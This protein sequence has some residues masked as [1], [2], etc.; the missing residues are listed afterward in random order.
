MA[1]LALAVTVRREVKL[2]RSRIKTR[3]RP[4]YITEQQG[5]WA[6]RRDHP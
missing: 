6:P 3:R 5:D 2:Y 1:A 4:G